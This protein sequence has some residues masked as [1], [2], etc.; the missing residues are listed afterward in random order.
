L[1]TLTNLAA[2]R[3]CIPNLFIISNVFISTISIG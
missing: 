1:D 2:G 3:A